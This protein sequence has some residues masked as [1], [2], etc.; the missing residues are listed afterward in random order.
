M[1]GTAIM[2]YY[3]TQGGIII[4]S[5]LAV[6][7]FS[8]WRET[9]VPGFRVPT[10]RPSH[11]SGAA[12][13]AHS[14]DSGSGGHAPHSHSDASEATLV[15]G[16][17]DSEDGTG[18]RVKLAQQQHGKYSVLDEDEAGGSGVSGELQLDVDAPPTPSDAA[19]VDSVG[20]ISSSSAGSSGSGS[21]SGSSGNGQTVMNGLGNGGSVSRKRV[22]ADAPTAT[23]V[24]VGDAASLRAQGVH[25]W[26][27]GGAAV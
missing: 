1:T 19:D 5:G 6:C 17:L 26:G 14:G 4:I 10:G 12:N 27:G 7:V 3:P 21:S 13:G 2:H 24:E 8:K 18:G 11:S 25:D 22:T 15:D 9:F 20:L 23:Q 16:K